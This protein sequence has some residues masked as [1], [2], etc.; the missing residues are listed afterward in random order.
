[1]RGS[2]LAVGNLLYSIIE[3]GEPLAKQTTAQGS[4]INQVEDFA[5]RFHLQRKMNDRLAN[6]IHRHNVQVFVGFR[7]M[8]QLNTTLYVSTS[9]VI[10]VGNTRAAVSSN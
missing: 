8:T 2:P 5:V 4:G 3:R 1:Q 6:I 9:K 10:Q 7:N